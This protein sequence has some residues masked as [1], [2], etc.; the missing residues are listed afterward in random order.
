MQVQIEYLSQSQNTFGYLNNRKT[1]DQTFM[2]ETYCIVIVTD[3]IARSYIISRLLFLIAITPG[4]NS[5][6]C[7]CRRAAISCV[8]LRNLSKQSNMKVQPTSESSSE[9]NKS[10]ASNKSKPEEQRIDCDSPAPM[11]KAIISTEERIEQEVQ[12]TKQSNLQQAG[13][14]INQSNLQT[15]TVVISPPTDE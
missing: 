2:M 15:L 3:N 5:S 7:R 11:H 1:Y 13:Q 14:T 4:P 10:S 6:I 9:K 12:M 8:F